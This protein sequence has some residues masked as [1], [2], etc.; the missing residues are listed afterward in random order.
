MN[1]IFDYIFL[2]TSLEYI[3]E[4]IDYLDILEKCSQEYHYW[5]PVDLRVSGIDLMPNHLVMSLYNHECVLGNNSLPRNYYVN[6]H[7]LFEGK[8]MSKSEGNFVLLGDMLEKYGSDITRFAL[9]KGF[10]STE[11]SINDNVFTYFNT[12]RAI[13][14][15]DC[16]RDSMIEL[17]NITNETDDDWEILNRDD[18]LFDEVFLSLM[19]IEKKSVIQ[20]YAEM[21]YQKILEIMFVNLVNIK[22]DYI[23]FAT[24]LKI[25]LLKSYLDLHLLLLYPIIPYYV[26]FLWKIMEDNG[27]SAVKL[28]SELKCEKIDNESI[29]VFNELKRYI[30]IMNKQL[31]KLQERYKRSKT[32]CDPENI[33]AIIIIYNFTDEHLRIIS[34][35]KKNGLTKGEKKFKKCMSANIKEYGDSILEVNEHVTLTET[36]GKMYFSKANGDFIVK[37]FIFAY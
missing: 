1:E 36:L 32:A 2:G 15:L 4:L 14:T 5:Y 16:E 29:F 8:K 9:V 13:N 11:H 23:S 18:D 30:S 3:D 28:L 19:E 25:N 17:I 10:C 34:G 21:N 33:T 24:R 31:N 27:L 20:A 35:I 6:G 26:R 12:D 37:N 22:N 7:L